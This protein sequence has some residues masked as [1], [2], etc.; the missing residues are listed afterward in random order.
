M[1]QYKEMKKYLW[2]TIIMEKRNE[3]EIIKQP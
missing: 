2:E 1:E 3:G